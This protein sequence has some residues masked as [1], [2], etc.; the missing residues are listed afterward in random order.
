LSEG[1]IDAMETIAETAEHLGASRFSRRCDIVYSDLAADQ[2][3][4][5]A[6]PRGTWI[7]QITDIDRQ[8]IQQRIPSNRTAVTS[9]QYLQLVC[10]RT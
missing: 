6:V 9:D 2:R 5:L 8:Q 10:R 3:N 7:G 1:I 4:H